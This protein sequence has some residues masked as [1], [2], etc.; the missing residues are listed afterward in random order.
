MSA[1]FQAAIL[2]LQYTPE[3]EAKHFATEYS[4]VTQA[5]TVNG[6]KGMKYVSTEAYEGQTY[7]VVNYMFEDDTYIVGLA[8]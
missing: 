3:L 8:F 7:T 1:C 2:Y 5:V 4:T 6:I